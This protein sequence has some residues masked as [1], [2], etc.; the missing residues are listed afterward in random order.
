MPF[1]WIR[2][3]LSHRILRTIVSGMRCGVLIEVDGGI[4]KDTID[5]ARGADMVVSGS[6][7]CES[8][9]YER[10]IESLKN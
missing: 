4:N 2:P 1:M 5:M 10:A 6:Y 3:C 9:D 8:T 7:V